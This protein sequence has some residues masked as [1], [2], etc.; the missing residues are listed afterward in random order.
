MKD[1]MRHKIDRYELPNTFDSIHFYP[2]IDSA[3][4]AFRKA[5]G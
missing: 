2:T 4:A 3:V 5:V 1:P